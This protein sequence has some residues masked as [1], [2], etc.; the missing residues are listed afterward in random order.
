MANFEYLRAV[1][2]SSPPSRLQQGSSANFVVVHRPLERRLAIRGLSVL[3]DGSQKAP[4]RKLRRFAHLKYARVKVALNENPAQL[5]P[6][7]NCPT[8][9]FRFAESRRF[10]ESTRRDG[11]SHQAAKFQKRPRLRQ[12]FLQAG[13]LRFK[14]KATAAA[15]RALRDCYAADFGRGS[16]ASITRQRH[17]GAC[18]RAWA[19]GTARPL[20]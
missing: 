19:T 13:S 2:N 7:Q 6:A 16:P 5:V 11:A 9:S 12:S 1:K 14:T 3:Y 4:S 18:C 20:F 15:R 17:K 8:H 10:S